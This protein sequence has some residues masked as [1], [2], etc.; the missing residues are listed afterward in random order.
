L[1]CSVFDRDTGLVSVC[2]F[3]SGGDFHASRKVGVA[4][5]SVFNK[6]IL[7]RR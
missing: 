1:C 6:H 5:P 2:P 3:F 4:L 7:R